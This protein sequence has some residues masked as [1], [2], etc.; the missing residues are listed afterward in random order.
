MI[1]LETS[2]LQQKN[3]FVEELAEEVKGNP[4]KTDALR[5]YI[6]I[7]MFL[8]YWTIEEVLAE[9]DLCPLTREFLVD[10][11]ERCRVMTAQQLVEWAM[12]A[13]EQATKEET[14]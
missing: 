7:Q 11:F 3:R 13:L 4:F 8:Q 1:D 14:R 12:R 6:A 5:R 2:F 10:Q 9:H